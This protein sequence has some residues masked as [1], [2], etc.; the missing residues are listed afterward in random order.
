MPP[1]ATIYFVRHGQTD[2]NAEWRLQGQLDIP[3][4]DKGRA[5][6]KRNGQTLSGLLPDPAALDFVAS[7]LAR[8]RETMELMRGA[9]GLEPDAYRT[10]ARL[11]EINFGDWQGH[12]WDELRAKTPD[13]VSARFADPWNAV[14][15]GPGGESYAMLS[16]RALAWL[17]GVER[18]T[19]VASHGGINRC[20]RGALEGLAEDEIPHLKVPQDK[21]LVITGGALEWM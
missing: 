11:M 4:N 17:D 15:P 14:A 10:D 8:T 7:P 13:T 21:V 6:A 5:Q 3:L 2:W 18:D 1:Q 12:T 20:L 16:A 9:L 19:V